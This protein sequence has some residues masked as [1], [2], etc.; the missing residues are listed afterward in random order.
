M[1]EVDYEGSFTRKLDAD[2]FSGSI[3]MGE[4][5]LVCP[6]ETQ[7]RDFTDAYA[8]IEAMPGVVIVEMDPWLKAKGEII[9]PTAVGEH[10]RPTSGTIISVGYCDWFDLSEV[11][12]GDHVLVER[13]KGRWINGAAFGE[14]R[15]QGQLRY[16]GTLTND[17]NARITVNPIDQGIVAALEDKVK[18]LG[19]KVYIKRDPVQATSLGLLL[20]SSERNSKATVIA[21]GPLSGLQPG[22]RVL[23]DRRSA[24]TYIEFLAE[25]YGL[26]GDPSDYVMVDARGG[27]LSRIYG[28]ESA[29]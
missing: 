13:M 23:Y 4:S 17:P 22:D 12:P 27:I 26:P 21:A 6:L 10:L 29:A 28:E 24:L 3:R 9:L 18:M 11:R 1:T 16:Y 7:D 2:A 5:T 15:C 25:R 8:A 19:H 20:P 14:Y